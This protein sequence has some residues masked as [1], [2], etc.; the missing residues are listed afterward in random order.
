MNRKNP[1]LDN[2]I[3]KAT[4]RKE[5]EKILKNN[6]VTV[7]QPTWVWSKK[8]EKLIKNRC[9]GYTLNLCSGFS[10]LGDVT[11]DLYM[12]ADVQGDMRN[13]P[14]RDFSFDTVVFDPP[15]HLNPH[16]FPKFHHTVREIERVCRLRIITRLGNNMWNFQ[17]HF[18]IV[19][20]WLIKR[21]SPQ[22]NLVIVWDRV[23]KHIDDF[24][25]IYRKQP[26]MA[27]YDEVLVL[28]QT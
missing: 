20:A 21:I 10:N 22:I 7:F 23:N 16:T 17:P 27:D 19:E 15:W 5:V 8:E 25:Q 11:F 1:P 28:Q 4:L 12:E 26:T 3:R 18:K 6:R 14:F 13:L 2:I 9:I 24:I